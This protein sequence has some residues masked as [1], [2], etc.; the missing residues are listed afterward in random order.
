VSLP[1]GWGDPASAFIKPWSDARPIIESR[2]RTLTE[3]S[4]QLDTVLG[5]ADELETKEV[6]LEAPY[7]DHD[8]RSEYSQH[9]ARR[10][11]PPSDRN[12]RLVF[13]DGRRNAVGYS[14]I[15]PTTK[16]VGRTAMNVPKRLDR[17]V[18][19]RADHSMLV[20]GDR[21][22]GANGFPFMSQ[23]GEY[24]RCAHAAIWSIARY[25]HCRHTTGRHPIAGIV[26]ATGTGQLPDRT[27]MSGGLTVEEV[28]QAL[29]MLGL[30][31]LSYTPKRQLTGTT[32]TEAMCRYLDSGFPIA[33]N[34][35]RHLTVLVG[36]AREKSGKVHWIRCN[37][38]E[39]PY[40]VV[41]DFDPTRAEDSKLGRWQSALVALPGRIHVPAESAQ[42]AAE[43]AFEEQLGA[44]KGPKHLRDAWDEK[45]IVGRTYAVKPAE[46]V[47]RL[48]TTG[49]LG[50]IGLH[51]RR[52]P[53]PAWAWVT[54]FRTLKDKDEPVLARVMI[55]ATGSRHTPTPVLADIDGWCV[56]YPLD[57]DPRA[58]QRA[59]SPVRYP[60]SLP[61]R[62]WE[63]PGG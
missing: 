34:T 42:T 51:H 60:S 15:R 61:N 24:G 9:F 16:P 59:P 3:S 58:K 19:C 20:Y 43:R 44:A 48:S 10:F 37:D 49:E 40:S 36:Y 13:L 41:S 53:M 62:T 1:K 39:G 21:L 27:T 52:V 11:Q 35:P 28:K 7:I 29:R 26:A 8:Y 25:Q 54:E 38:N 18:S 22:D 57:D 23:D 63:T 4:R 32:F 46:M 2:Y 6:I 55:D 33:V 17:Y 5:L 56:Y 47:E 50:D 12:E 45:K 30:P 14:V 31:V